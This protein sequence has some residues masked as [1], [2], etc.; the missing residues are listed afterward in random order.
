[1][2]SFLFACTLGSGPPNSALLDDFGKVNEFRLQD[3]LARPVELR[4]LEGRVWVANFIFTRCP[5]ICPMLSAHM[6]EVVAHYDG[7][8]A[9]RFVSFSV[10]PDFDTPPVLAE[11]AARFDAPPERW[12]FLTGPMG[13]VREVV[14]NAFRQVMEKSPETTP[15]HPESILHGSRFVVVDRKGHIRA[16]PDPLE[17]G[18]DGLYAAVDAALAEPHP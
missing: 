12:W 18:K 2:L 13:D 7:N 6:K 3:Q 14:V 17:S 4:T 1:M 11:Y 5:D 15:G 8:D 10:D 9:V 16:F